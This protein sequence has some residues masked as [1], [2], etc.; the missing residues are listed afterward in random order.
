MLSACDAATT[1]NKYLKPDE[2]R[3]SSSHV[4][5]A[6]FVS[7]DRN[8]CLAGMEGFVLGPS[9]LAGA[10]SEEYQTF[11]IHIESQLFWVK[12]M[13]FYTST[14]PSSQ[15]VFQCL[16]YKSHGAEGPHRTIKT[17]C[18]HQYQGQHDTIFIA[19]LHL[20]RSICTQLRYYPHALFS[21]WQQLH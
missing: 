8:Q 17:R 13:F 10:S 18:F 5:W 7:Q 21:C 2:S 6:L 9:H 3:V 15:H 20:L 11:S 1:V 14:G 12:T 4:G 19:I 16:F